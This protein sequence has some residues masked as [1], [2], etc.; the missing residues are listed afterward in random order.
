LSI[1]Q[2]PEYSDFDYNLGD[3][4][5]VIDP[6]FFGTDESE[7]IIVTEETNYLDSPQKNSL[8]V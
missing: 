1:S 4:T 6:E 8:K 2:L 7:E 3:K 5:H